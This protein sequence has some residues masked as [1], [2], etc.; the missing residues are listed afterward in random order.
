MQSDR[1]AIKTAIE[2]LIALAMGDGD[3]PVTTTSLFT[4]WEFTMLELGEDVRMLS[5]EEVLRY[6]DLEDWPD[7]LP[8]IDECP[9]D[10]PYP[11]Y[12]IEMLLQIRQAA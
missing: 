2:T 7:G 9:G 5:H 11:A 3:L 1:H 8:V 4:T 10:R 6:W 12:V